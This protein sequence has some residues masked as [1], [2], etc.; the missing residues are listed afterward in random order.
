MLED[1]LY[2]WKTFYKSLYVQQIHVLIYLL[3]SQKIFACARLI[4]VIKG[5]RAV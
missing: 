3:N 2:V 5:M 1:I 4:L